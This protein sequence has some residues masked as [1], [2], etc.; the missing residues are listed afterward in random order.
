L[1]G[2]RLRF[3]LPAA[4]SNG[5]VSGRW[6]MFSDPG[7][8]ESRRSTRVRLK[9]RIEAKGF[10]EPLTCEGETI[11]VN[12]HG[13]LIST[14]VPLHVGMTIEIH[15]ILT[16][17]R[18]LAK[19]VYVDP[20]PRHC[21]IGL[22][23]P[24]IFGEHLFHRMIGRKAIPGDLRGIPWTAGICASRGSWRK[25]AISPLERSGSVETVN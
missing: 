11:V 25:I 13:A 3:P 22:E 20:E 10:A 18:G 9:V 5:S 7:A 2:S 23:R 14:A 17:R 16:D 21:G 12:L 8:R 15:V 1:A 19:M 24:Q 6:H 4:A